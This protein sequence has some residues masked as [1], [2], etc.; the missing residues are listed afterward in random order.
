MTRERTKSLTR[1][2]HAHTEHI[3]TIQR[4]KETY[5][6]LPSTKIYRNFDENEYVHFT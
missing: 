6:N 3:H 4:K 5:G 1:K 2:T